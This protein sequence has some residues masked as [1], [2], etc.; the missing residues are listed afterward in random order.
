MKCIIIGDIVW[1][2]KGL[3]GGT[4]TGKFEYNLYKMAPELDYVGLDEF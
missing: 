3:E 2:F 1:S 4:S